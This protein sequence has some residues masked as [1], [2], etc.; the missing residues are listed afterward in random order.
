MSDGSDIFSKAALDKL[1]SPDRL[2][3]LLPITTPIGWMSLVA[4][5]ILLISVMFGL[6]VKG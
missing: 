2:D 6:M 5:G 1:R 3:M 4:I